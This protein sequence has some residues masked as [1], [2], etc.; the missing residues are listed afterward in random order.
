M[1]Y[2]IQVTNPVPGIWYAVDHERFDADFDG[3]GYVPNY[4]QASGSTQWEAM[5]ALI[6]QLEEADE[7][8]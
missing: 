2:D 5:R 7:N 8:S 1:K 4:A 6:D 3:E